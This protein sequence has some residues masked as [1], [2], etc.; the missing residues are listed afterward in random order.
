MSTEDIDPPPNERFRRWITVLLAALREIDY[1]E[2]VSVRLAN[3]WG[4]FNSL[5]P[6]WTPCS[7]LDLHNP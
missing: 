7:C 3:A 1:G 6:Y 4:H 2:G 5:S